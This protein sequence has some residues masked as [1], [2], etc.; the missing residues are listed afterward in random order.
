MAATLLDITAGL[1]GRLSAVGLNA[2]AVEPS[3]ITPPA[4]WPFLRQP[5]ATYDQTFDGSMTWF[6]S[7]YVLVGASS[8]QH[9][10]TNLMPYLAPSGAKSVKAAIEADPSLGGL[11]DVYAV[12]T[13]VE[14][15]GGYELGGVRYTGAV[16]LCQVLA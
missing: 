3:S 13:G 12:V 4:A 16:L 9:A 2:N 8:D 15:V 10:Q 5:A 1:K 7:I 6:F 14:S 11:P